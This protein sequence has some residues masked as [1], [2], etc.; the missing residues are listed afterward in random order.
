MGLVKTKRIEPDES[1]QFKDAHIGIN[2][3]KLE[4][5]IGSLHWKINPEGHT[6]KIVDLLRGYQHAY[7]VELKKIE[8]APE[9]FT[10]WDR[11][12]AYEKATKGIL[13]A[14]LVDFNYENAANHIDAGVGT[15]GIL[16]NELRSFLVDI[17]G[18]EGQRHLLMLSKL[19]TQSISDGI[20]A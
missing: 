6:K 19:A 7:E 13:E 18:R 3:T 11:E 12:E 14:A 16:A 2:T 17:G 4:G 20:K 10:T 5:F 9:S 1:G 8:G 15:L